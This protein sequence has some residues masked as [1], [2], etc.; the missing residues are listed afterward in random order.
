MPSHPVFLRWLR[1]QINGDDFFECFAA[2]KLVHFFG[3]TC[4]ISC[5]GGGPMSP[6]YVEFFSLK[7]KTWRTRLADF[8]GIFSCS[9]KMLKNY[10]LDVII[11]YGWCFP[12]IFF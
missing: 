12:N 4:P 11:G 3:L 2:K 6:S 8:P 1:L 5:D 9:E 7:K 10:M